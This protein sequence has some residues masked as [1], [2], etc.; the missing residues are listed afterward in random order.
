MPELPEVES[1]RLG[2]KRSIKNKTILNVKVLEEKIVASHSNIRVGSK[3]KTKNFIQNII[4]KKV[5]DITR[6]AKNIII[7][8]EDD[9]IILVHL[10]MTGQLIFEGTPAASPV[11]SKH[12]HIIFELENGNL[13]YN[14]VRKFGYVLYYKSLEEAI[15]NNHFQKIGLEPFDKNFTLE[16]FEEEIKKLKM[17]NSAKNIKTVLLEQ[18]IVVGCGNIY[19]DEVCFASK[20]LP[21]RLCSSLK[22]SELENLYNNI[23]HILSEAIRVGGSSIS[24]YK[25]SDGSK[26]GY[27]DQH[28]VYGKAGKLCSICLSINKN[29]I[30]RKDIIGGRA[31]VFCTRCQK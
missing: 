26:G 19:S 20:V 18:S 3:S 7:I 9:S 30:L 29:T 31:T 16:Y 28:K 15:D 12:T 8:L 14:D 4:G 22:K 17:K 21:S 2:L 5:K 27:V 1:I 23:K 10:K 11:Q 13:Y 24:D 6:R 25:L